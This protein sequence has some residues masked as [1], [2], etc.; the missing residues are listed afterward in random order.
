MPH[1]HHT[2]SLGF[3]RQT[4]P[5]GVHV[6]QIYSNDE[7]RLSSLLEF[8]R[9]GLV[10]G[11]RTACFTDNLDEKHL[12]K[13]LNQHGL[14]S[15]ALQKS[16]SFS[17]SG[18]RAVYFQDGCFDPDRMLGLLRRYHK[19]SV[20][21]DYP[22]ARIIGEMSSEVQDIPGGSRL[23]EYESR[24]SL[25]LMNHPVTAVCQY[26][27]NAFDGA[28]LMKVLKVH[29]MMVIRG[30]VVRNPYYIAP[31]EFLEQDRRRPW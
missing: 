26:D 18:A 31:A 5:A 3:T 22:A 21:H 30:V 10:A 20:A 14:S 19:D 1:D 7:E 23:L 12:A 2:I 4:F 11:E 15:E 9:S 25:L 6:C 27:A 16:G 13:Y 29:P 24:V 8:L 28:T 17:V